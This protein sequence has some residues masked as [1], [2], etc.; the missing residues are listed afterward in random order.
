MQRVQKCADKCA[1]LLR[2]PVR[3]RESA[4]LC[5]HG[6]SVSASLRS[7]SSAS[8]KLPRERAVDELCEEREKKQQANVRTLNDLA[9]QQVPLVVVVNLA[10]TLRVHA[11]R[12]RWQTISLRCVTRRSVQRERASLSLS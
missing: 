9:T 3:E 2:K 6:V 1:W 12:R 10:P 11:G 7:S 8:P 4:R 5:A